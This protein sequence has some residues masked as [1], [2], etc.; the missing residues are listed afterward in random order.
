MKEKI[1]EKGRLNAVCAVTIKFS[2]NNL[3]IKP[4]RM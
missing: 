2:S 1:R 4:V 3:I